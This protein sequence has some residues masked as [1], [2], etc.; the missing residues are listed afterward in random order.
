MSRKQL[1]GHEDRLSILDQHLSAE[2]EI[3]VLNALSRLGTV[4]H[5]PALG[6]SSRVDALFRCDSEPECGVI[7]DILTVSDR[8]LRQNNPDAAL[9]D[10]VCNMASERGLRLNSF[11]FR[12]GSKSEMTQTGLKKIRLLLPGES[13]FAAT[14]LGPEFEQFLDKIEKSPDQAARY[15]YTKKNQDI[16]VTI[17]YAPNQEFG[18]MWSD[19]YTES[20]SLT[21]NPVFDRLKEKARQLEKT[22]DSESLRGIV[23]CDGGC[24]LVRDNMPRDG[25][26]IGDIV[27][28]FLRQEERIAFVVVLR[29]KES[30]GAYGRKKYRVES[31]LYRGVSFESLWPEFDQ[32]IE[33]LENAFPAPVRS[34]VN[35]LNQL[36]AGGLATGSS[37][38][39]GN[40][41]SRDRVKISARVILDLLA[42][43]LSQE[44]FFETY[45]FVPNP[46]DDEK[47]NN[48]FERSLREGRMITE[49]MI[50][51]RPEHDDDWIEFRFGDVDPAISTFKS[52]PASGDRPGTNGRKL[53]RHEEDE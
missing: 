11:G 19:D 21:D 22:G 31:R 13:R 41:V 23:L 47:T 16:D 44:E 25:Y 43:R 26:D 14:V 48:P 9:T 42:G 8:G 49:V 37:F 32:Q 53:M 15:D 39:G 12:I 33:C 38:R 29:V 51:S 18:I 6:G 35:A 28:A 10:A 40:S 7:A 34:P 45:K 1:R 27:R 50:E 3:A 2:W 36:N 20:V 24:A 30:R 4:Q 17:T 46:S 52:R 5:E